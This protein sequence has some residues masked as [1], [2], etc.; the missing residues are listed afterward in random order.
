[1]SKKLVVLVLV[2]GLAF[3]AS[4][5]LIEFSDSALLTMTTG[6]SEDSTLDLVTDIA[7]DPGVQFDFT[8]DDESGWQDI[9]IAK[10]SPPVAMGDTWTAKVKNVS[11]DGKYI[12]VY[13]FFQ[14][15]GWKYRQGATGY[16][17]AY[18][19]E[20]ILTMVNPATT[21]TDSVGIKVGT[22]DWMGR[23]IGG[24]AAIQV[25]PTVPEPATLALLGL[26]GLLMRRKQR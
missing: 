25:L 26:G 7:G 6:S 21:S 15:D 13:A 4:A 20:V 8:F 18:G 5:A 19:D 14:V 9:A 3:S 22:N 23:E 16:N 2:S 1:M 10:Y 17:L 12:T 24:S 11:A